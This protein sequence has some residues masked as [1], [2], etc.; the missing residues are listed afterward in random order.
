MVMGECNFKC[1]GRVLPLNT[2]PIPL[3]QD[4]STSCDHTDSSM[5]KSISD[6]YP[7]NEAMAPLHVATLAAYLVIIACLI[8]ILILLSF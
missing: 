8:M 4:V 6:L 5:S 7:T 2:L 1:R 3:Y